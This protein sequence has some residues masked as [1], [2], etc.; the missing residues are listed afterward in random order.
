MPIDT[1][2]YLTGTILGIALTFAI[3]AQAQT[4]PDDDA[5]SVQQQHR[6]PDPEQQV[7]RLTKR[8]GLSPEQAAK[9]NDILHQRQQQVAAIRGDTS[10]EAADRKQRVRGA[11]AAGTAQL[12]GVL[13][14]Q[15]RRIFDDLH[16]RMQDKREQQ[17]Q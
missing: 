13:T 7:A 4:T 10:L 3:V 16:Q 5:P 17:K 11:M 12:E 2:R 9:I 1:R 6:A 15:Q 8:L 14:E